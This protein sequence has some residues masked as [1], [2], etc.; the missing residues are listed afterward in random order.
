MFC[1]DDKVFDQLDNLAR[2][3]VRK[4]HIRFG[5]FAIIVDETQ[6]VRSFE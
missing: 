1:R 2:M 4:V 5:V 3:L 6:I